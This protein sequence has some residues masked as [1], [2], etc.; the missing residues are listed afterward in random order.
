MPQVEFHHGIGD[1][2]AYACRLLRKASRAGV[3]LVVTGD[4]AA[5]QAL[6]RLL[7]VF[8]DQEF[9]PH[10]LS[11]GGVSLPERL[12]ATP[13]W[14]S[15]DPASAPGP[16][17]VLVNLGREV[18]PGAERFDRLFDLVSSQPDDR[19]E[20]RARWK[21]YA[22]RGWAVRPHDVNEGATP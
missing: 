22:A 12:H 13:V 20:G 9:L 4:V 1:K 21:A 19:Q 15:D 3:Q 8:D 5:L 6:D 16:R 10:V 14:L 18:P 2:Q 17:S 11:T 7:W